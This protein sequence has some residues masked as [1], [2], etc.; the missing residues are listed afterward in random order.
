MYASLLFD[1][2]L[3]EKG[4]YDIPAA[5]DY[6][7]GTTGRKKIKYVGYSEGGTTF[8]IF[9]STKPHYNEKIEF[10][11]LLAPAVYLHHLKQPLLLPLTRTWPLILVIYSDLR[12]NLNLVFV[13]LF[14]LGSRSDCWNSRN[15]SQPHDG[16]D[17]CPFVQ[18]I[19]STI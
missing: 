10:A 11:V 8:A 7:L 6:I 18:Q 5:V 13:I 1:F 19:F 15:S 9:A 2:S 4:T 3:T 16:N 17:Q 12:V 14:F